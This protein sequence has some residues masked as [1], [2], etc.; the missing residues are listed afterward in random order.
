MNET[1]REY[2]RKYISPVKTFNTSLW[3]ELTDWG[4]TEGLDEPS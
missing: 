1:I 4:L 3:A 2:A